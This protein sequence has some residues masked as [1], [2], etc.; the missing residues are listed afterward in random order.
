MVSHGTWAGYCRKCPCDPCREAGRLYRAARKAGLPNPVPSARKPPKPKPERPEGPVRRYRYRITPSVATQHKLARVFGGARFFYNA[1]IAL[2]RAEFE[3]GRAHPSGFTAAKLLVT[4]TE[5]AWAREL[6]SPVLRASV[7]QA[8]ET[9][10]QFF[11]SA[12]GRRRGMRMGRPKFKKRGSRASAVFPENAFRIRGGH[13]STATA[14]GGRL[15]LSKV[16]TVPVNWHRPLPGPPSSVTVIREADGTWWATF[17][18]T[19]APLTTATPTRRARAAGI[20]LG[21]TDFAA[22][23]YSDGTR[24]KIPHPRFLRRGERQ[25][26][27]AQKAH[28]RKVK[29]SNN[30]EKARV[31]VARLHARVTNQRSNHARQ[32]AARLTRENQAVAVE[33]LNIAGLGRTRL[34]KSIHDAGWATFL[35]YLD[36]AAQA[37]GTTLTATPPAFPSSRVCSACGVNTGPKPLSVRVWTCD[38]CGATHDRDYNAAVNILIA[39]GP[40]ETLNA[41]GPAVRHQLSAP[42][43]GASARRGEA[44]T[45]PTPRASRSWAEGNRPRTR[46]TVEAIHERT[47][48]DDRTAHRRNTSAANV[49]TRTRRTATSPTPTRAGA[50][51]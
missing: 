15:F 8:A 17:V 42:V 43:R 22:V 39:A 37:R 1:Y 21:L 14:P 33:T 48:G 41:C 7:R 40:A 25:L 27:R 13:E 20:D 45:H 4:G 44:G 5:H 19:V 9:Y 10:R 49:E 47:R 26:A 2:A 30:R 11:D 50:I 29:G 28:A 46:G 34:A 51:S 32:L 35:R 23:V 6:P 38:D 24:E 31:R 36:E 18:V 16:G 3:A 12:A